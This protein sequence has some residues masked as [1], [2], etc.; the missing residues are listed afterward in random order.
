MITQ[1]DL[2]VE[3]SVGIAC[4]ACIPNIVFVENILVERLMVGPQ[5][6]VV[7][8]PLFRLAVRLIQKRLL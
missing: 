3:P 1:Y 2:R 4:A 8:G 6:I 7:I 5:R